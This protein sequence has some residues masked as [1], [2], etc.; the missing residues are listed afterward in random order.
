VRAR[1]QELKPGD[2]VATAGPH[3]GVVSIG[4]NLCAP[5]PEGV[6]FEQ[7]AY[8][9]VAAIG[10]EGVRLARATLGE[11]V[12]VIGLGLVGQICVAILKA[13]GCRVLGTDV[14]T[15][16]LE[17]AKAFGADAV[18]PGSPLDA[19]KSFT[20][21]FGIDAVVITAATTSNEPIELAA[22]AC[23]PRG[24]IVLVGVVGLDLP[25]PPFFQKELEFTVS[26]SLGP[27]RGDPVYEEKGIDYPI[28]HARWTARRNMEAV[29]ALMA[30]RQA[31]G[32][33]AHDAPLSHREAADLRPRHREEGALHGHPPRVSAR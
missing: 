28:G 32:G 1:R 21:G 2:R 9:S 27:G 24:R 8:T 5:I 17:Q 31:A 15:E 25:R 29:L 16:R 7:A 26:S 10:L 11:S 23:R 14:D 22:A 33:A 3:A 19:V 4:R 30:S 13:Q 6:T 12:L 20:G 18:A